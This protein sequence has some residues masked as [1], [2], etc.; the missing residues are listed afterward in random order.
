MA[1]GAGRAAS[2]YLEAIFEVGAVGLKSDGE[3]LE[4]SQTRGDEIAFEVL[5]Q[6]HGPAV[7]RACRKVLRDEHDAEDAFQATF[8][9]LARRAG[10]VRNRDA[11]GSWLRGVAARVAVQARLGAYR[12]R[13]HERRSV[14]R[15][16]PQDAAG[17][18]PVRQESLALLR[19]E[20]DRLPEPYRS[21]VVLCY[22]EGLTC[23]QASARLRRPLGTIT[24]QLTRARR[25]LH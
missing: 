4:L 22:Q 1:I 17:P 14:E 8:L 3:L 18:D 13:T 11:V 19:E 6:R 9:I 2:R 16:P 20:I 23:E 5:V 24:V 10:S 25:A 21:P 15:R 7:L 12:R